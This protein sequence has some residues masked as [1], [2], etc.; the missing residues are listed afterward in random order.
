[1]IDAVASGSPPVWVRVAA[2]AVL[3]AISV[4]MV[5]TAL[6]MQRYR[7]GNWFDKDAV[8]HDF[9]LNFLCDLTRVTGVNGQPSMSAGWGLVGLVSI[10]LALFP[11]WLMLP[12]FFPERAALGMLVRV[13]GGISAIAAVAVP[14]V[15]SDRVGDKHGYLVVLAAVPGVVAFAAGLTGLYLGGLTPVW[16]L[17]LAVALLLAGTVDAALFTH[18][19]VTA[20]TPYPLLAILQRVAAI[21][22]VVLMTALSLRMLRPFA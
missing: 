21:L 10:L 9:W 4:F 1:M 6:A 12:G 20:N 18:H 16:L 22:L 7:G 15:P 5:T 11:F 14:L 3:V 19:V 2:I 8:A 17:A 13:A